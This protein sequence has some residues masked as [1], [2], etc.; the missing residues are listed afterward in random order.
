MKRLK[1]RKP[2]HVWTTNT[3]ISVHNEFEVK[4][5]LSKLRS[6]I[7]CARTSM[8]QHILFSRLFQYDDK[9]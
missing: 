1:S 5:Y 7:F 6:H 3:T 2:P 8:L 9:I 4:I